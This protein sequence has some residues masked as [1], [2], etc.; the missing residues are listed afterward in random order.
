[1]E[2][3]TH[4]LRLAGPG[5]ICHLV[6]FLV[7]KLKLLISFKKIKTPDLLLKT[8]FFFADLRSIASKFQLLL[9]S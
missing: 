7:N 3:D 2:L 5:R 8:F 1:M 6:N 9:R 4:R